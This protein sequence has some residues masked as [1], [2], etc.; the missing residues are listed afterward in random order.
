[1]PIAWPD[2]LAFRIPPAAN[3]Y[4]ERD[5]MVYALG[6]GMGIDPMDERE[7]AF[8]LEDRLRVMPTMATVLTWDDRWLYRIGIDMSKQVHG[9]Q[10]I[11]I[12][13]ALPAAATVVATTR[14]TEVADKG[15]ERGAILT[16]E[17][18]VR[19]TATSALLATNTSTVVARADGGFGGPNAPRPAP[20]PVP[21]RA[22]D[23]VFEQRTLP[24]Q[25]LLYRLAGDRNPLHA[26]PTYAAKGGFPRPI[27]HGL[28][29]FGHACGAVVRACCGHDPDLIREIGTRFTRPVFPGET[30]RTEMWRD[31]D[32]VSFRSRVVERDV[33]VLDHGR[34]VLGAA[35]EP[36]VPGPA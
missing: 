23:A 16:F 26:D 31:R 21:E 19:D 35:P 5:T 22:A 15:P 24:Q 7:L 6:I 9:E 34:A 28:C 13:R 8:V 29:T 27:L 14:I 18:E 17:T 4:T 32:I 1:M 12:H 3:T 33:I 20:H 36:P 30:I 25:A 10:T 11:R 2:I